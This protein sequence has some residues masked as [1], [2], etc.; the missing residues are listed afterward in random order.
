MAKRKQFDLSVAL[1]AEENDREVARLF[2]AELRTA[3]KPV[4]R[5]LPIDRIL[6]NPFQ[7]RRDFDDLEELVRSIHAHGFV[8]RLRVRAHPQQ[9]DHFQLV[10]GERRLRAARAAGMQ[11]VPCEIAEHSDAQLIEIGLA[12]N[13]QRQDLDPLEE[14]YAFRT[15]IA[16]HNYT[17]Q[18][19]AD[20][21]GKDVSYVAERLHILE[22][23]PEDVQA[24]VRQRSDTLRAAREIAKLP[25][26]AARAPLIAQVLERHLPTHAVRKLVRE[27]L[28]R[29][30]A[31]PETP[32]TKRTAPESPRAAAEP[33][34]TTTAREHE[35]EGSVDGRAIPAGQTTSYVEHQ[36]ARDATML[37]GIGIDRDIRNVRT[38]FERWQRQLDTLDGPYRDRLIQFMLDEHLQQVER[39]VEAIKRKS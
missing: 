30:A 26:A 7:A 4:L 10:F 34:T 28:D 29:A 2:D 16:Q 3:Q 18:R 22:D 17:Q 8:S 20:R 19:L 31:Q 23:T 25:D 39:L 37:A 36:P 1:P 15:L 13:I 12:E 32:R 6:P 5:D 21:I 11:T 14:A 24:M 9:A 27:E 35:P 33:R 38:I